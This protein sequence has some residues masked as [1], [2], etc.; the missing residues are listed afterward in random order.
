MRKFSY[1]QL[2]W[3]AESLTNEQIGFL[4]EGD[5]AQLQKANQNAGIDNQQPTNPGMSGVENKAGMKPNVEQAQAPAQD[6]KAQISTVCKA[7][8]GGKLATIEPQQ[9]NNFLKNA[10]ISTKN[11]AQA[12]KYAI[13][14]LGTLFKNPKQIDMKSLKGVVSGVNNCLGAL[15]QTRNEV[16]ESIVSDARKAG[17]DINNLI[18]NIKGNNT[19]NVFQDGIKLNINEAL[20]NDI[21]RFNT[22]NETLKNKYSDNQI[23]EVSKKL[24]SDLTIIGSELTESLSNDTF[25]SRI[26][27][28]YNLSMNIKNLIRLAE[29]RK[30]DISNVQKLTKLAE[31]MTKRLNESISALKYAT[32]YYNKNK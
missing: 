1:G 17:V 8:K 12:V 27:E 3:L 28:Y 10:K 6:D 31:P 19:Y 18:L 32:K 20:K 2:K 13:E 4:L 30:V 21:K 26:D 14:Y 22:L 9:L 24:I 11:V 25:E 16:S 23:S 15:M 29:S 5:D 7:I